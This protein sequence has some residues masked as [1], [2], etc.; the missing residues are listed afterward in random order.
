MAFLIKPRELP[1]MLLCGNLL[2]WV[3]R[4]LHLGNMVT[5]KI[6]GGQLDMKQK[7][8]RYVDMNCSINQEFS[9]AHPTS[10]L[11]LNRI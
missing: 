2:P 1:N 6:D 7:T 4:L 5:N 11:A 9:F 8:A 10:K 3:D